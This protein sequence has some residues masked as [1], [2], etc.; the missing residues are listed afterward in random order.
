MTVEKMGRDKTD[1]IMSG[2]IAL[3]EHGMWGIAIVVFVASILVPILKMLGLVVLLLSIQSRWILNPRLATK[4]YRILEFVGR[5]S[6][7]DI[8]VIALLVA[9]VE[10]GRLTSISAE[11][12]AT[13][14]GAVVVFT[15]LAATSF[16]S[17][18]I[19]DKQRNQQ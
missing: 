3:T 17:R 12:G 5:W 2:V 9:L 4:I 1:T 6:M 13:F 10:F 8:F 19:W 16:D 14:F 7:L 11:P 15:M 18:L